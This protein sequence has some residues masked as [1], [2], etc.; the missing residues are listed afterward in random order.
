MMRPLTSPRCPSTPT[1]KTT[2]TKPA[3]KLAARMPGPT[4]LQ[5]LL[6]AALDDRRAKLQLRQR[7]ILRPIDSVHI[8]IDGR[9]YVNF[10]SNNYL[11]LTYH[12]RVIDAI[13]RATRTHGA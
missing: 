13:E 8:E 1:T 6:N 12:P 3:S 10:C 4:T 2:V 5:N 11:G 9:R 7:Q